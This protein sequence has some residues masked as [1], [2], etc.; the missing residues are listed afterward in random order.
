[1]I[2]QTPARPGGTRNDYDPANAWTDPDGHLHFAHLR[3]QRPL[4]QRRSASDQ[5]PWL[6]F[7]SLQGRDVAHLE[8]S[9]VFAMLTSDPNTIS[10]EMD[11]EISTW[12][13]LAGRNGHVCDSAVLY[14]GKHGSVQDTCRES[15]PSCCAGQRPGS[16]QAFSGEG[17]NTLLRE[18]VFT[19][20]VPSPATEAVHLNLYVFGNNRNPL[21]S[22]AEV[23]VDSFEIPTVIF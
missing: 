18:H 7:L 10:S 19:S 6:W 22:G 14:S 3:E 12:G 11:I 1:M 5:K 16:F 4:D 8:P 21:P 13:E 2:R 23:V 17:G 9:V 15:R 20:G